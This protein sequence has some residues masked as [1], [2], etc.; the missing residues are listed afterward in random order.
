MQINRH[1]YEEFF[2]LYVDKELSAADKRAVDVFVEENPDLQME[3]WA[4]QQTVV[5]AGDIVLDKK[6]WLYM[7][8][9]ISALQEDLLLYTDDELTATAKKSV[10]TLVATHKTAQAE[11]NIL[12]KTKLQ[13]DMRVVFADKQSLYR[14][15]SNRVVAITWWR[16]AAAAVI[17]GFV[18]SAGVYVFKHNYKVTP[19]LP[20][21][22]NVD[23]T[24]PKE[25]K[26][27]LPVNQSTV[28]QGKKLSAENVAYPSP[29]I[30][31]NATAI[32]KIT[33]G[34]DKN[35]SHN[36][37]EASVVVAE[38]NNRSKK[39]GNDLPKSYLENINSLKSN[40]ATIV[41]VLPANDN[42][43]KISGNNDATIH[44]KVNTSN[45]FIA[46]NNNRPDQNVMATQVV[47][48]NTERETSNHYL[49][50]DHDKEKRTALGG[51]IRKAKRIIER[52]TNVT[53]GE[54]IKIAG[55]EIALK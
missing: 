5:K 52:T 39:R 27:V 6:E 26:A 34:I 55:F 32:D 23:K 37:N 40:K 46:G 43:S 8:E 50:I 18:L 4:L 31:N 49:H 3:L 44:T 29:Q 28:Q 54:G 51:F 38:K 30:K 16:A 12:K 35:K 2:L 47:N 17:L 9:E 14:K 21:L 36:N 19:G 22:V 25:I 10:E 45:T 15:E 11:L 53:S 20:G 41:G 42:S 1:N 13:P 7:Q 33:P 24:N 48:E